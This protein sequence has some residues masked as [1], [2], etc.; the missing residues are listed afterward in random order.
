MDFRL[1]EEQKMIQNMV[2]NFTHKEVE[3]RAKEIDETDKFPHDLM[4]R[5]AQL[6]LVGLPYPEKYGGSG[7]GYLTYVLAIE[8]IAQSSCCVAGCLSV[9]G[10]SEEAIFRFGT[11]D[12]KQKYLAPLASRRK[13]GLFCLQRTGYGI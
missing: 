13:I 3:P 9:Q 11:E 7:M 6:N 8:Q 4:K 1:T 2:R 5:L 12:Q 10:N